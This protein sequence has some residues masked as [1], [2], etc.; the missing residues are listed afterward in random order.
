MT[1]GSSGFPI[2]DGQTVVFIGDSI[3]DCDRRGAAAPF[4]SGYVRLVIDLI[5]ARYPQRV[6]AFHNK[7][8]GGDTSTGLVSRWGDDVIQ[9][10]PDWVSL[11]I[12][13]NDLHM[14][15]GGGEFGIDPDRYAQNCRAV[16]QRTADETE[17]RLIL[18]DPFYMSEETDPAS[19]RAKVLQLIP[20][21]LQ[22]VHELAEEF[23]T[24]HVP[25]HEAFARQLA[26]RPADMFGDEPVH[27]N[28]RGHT[29]IA[30]AWLRTVGWQQEDRR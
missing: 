27:P 24:L 9:F 13:I 26:C 14:H 8:I 11:M 28:Q 15:L 25:L 21:Y 18:M 5:T 12:G 2:L 7:G 4:G 3:T 29:V 1:P 23:D 16:L 22:V 20:E 19:Q 10:D 30:E 17:A 6:I